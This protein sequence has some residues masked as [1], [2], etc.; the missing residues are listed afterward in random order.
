MDEDRA[1]FRKFV[2]VGNSGSGKTT[3]ARKLAGLTGIKHIELDSI[4]HLPNWTACP[5]EQFREELEKQILEAEKTSNGWVTCGNYTRATQCFHHRKADCVVWL[6]LPRNVIMRRVVKRT[7]K[8][9]FYRETLWNGNRESLS[10]L[11]HWNPERNIMV[12]AWTSFPIVR[13]RYEKMTT[14]GTWDHLTVVRLKTPKE[15]ADFLRN[16]QPE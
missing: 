13:A 10:N 1:A 8:R 4:N 15:I 7:L 3:F 16:F 6:D 11:Y 9:A 12:W 14:E 5:P 2:V